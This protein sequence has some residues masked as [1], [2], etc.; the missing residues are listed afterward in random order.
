MK[1]NLLLTSE[2]N[3]SENHKAEFIRKILVF[4]RISYSAVWSQ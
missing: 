3:E 1:I 4:I 2:A